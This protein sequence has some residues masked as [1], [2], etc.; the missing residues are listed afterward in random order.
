MKNNG[1][2]VCFL[3]SKKK[4]ENFHGFNTLKEF[5]DHKQYTTNGILRYERIFGA[6]FISTGG[7]ESTEV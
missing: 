3:F 5:I 1:N 7:R 4:L 2:Q 6:G